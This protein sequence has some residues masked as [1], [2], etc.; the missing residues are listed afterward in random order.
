MTEEFVSRVSILDECTT[1]S[2]YERLDIIESAIQAIDEGVRDNRTISMTMS[3]TQSVYFELLENVKNAL[4]RLAQ[5]ALSA[6]N[7]Y[8][9]NNAKLCQKY[10]NVIAKGLEKNKVPIAHETYEYPDSKGYP[11]TMRSAS[12]EADVLRLQK[13]VAAGQYTSEEIAY[14]VDQLIEDFGRKVLDLS[15]DP[16]ELKDS[17]QEIVTKRYRGNKTTIIIDVDTLDDWIKSIT[18]YRKDREDITALKKDLVED[19]EILKRTMASATKPDKV[20]PNR[21]PIK[22]AYDPEAENFY[23][24]EHARFSDIH[25]EMM[26]LFKSYIEIYKEAF[27]TKLKLL[28]EKVNDQRNTLTEVLTRTGTLAAINAKSPIMDGNKPIPYNPQP[29]S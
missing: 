14:R 9:T 25:T 13:S 16:W 6:L 23:E 26:R 4:L 5:Q 7:S 22:K 1:G 21:S 10:R 12:V 17:V 8:Y 29:V 3:Y 28:D 27:N 24:H 15:P 11:R 20:L 19:Y 2:I 18:E